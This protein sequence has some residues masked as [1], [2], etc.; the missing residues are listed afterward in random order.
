MKTK[1][2]LDALKQEISALGAKLAELSDDEIAVVA[3]G[4]A[5]PPIRQDEKYVLGFRKPDQPD[6]PYEIHFYSIP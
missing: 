2:E 6:S 1:E 5:M 3:G 4:K